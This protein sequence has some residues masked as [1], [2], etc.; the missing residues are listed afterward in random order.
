MEVKKEPIQEENKKD[1]TKAIQEKFA[2][3][4]EMQKKKVMET[5][6]T[7]GLDMSRVSKITNF[8]F[9]AVKSTPKISKML[10]TQKEAKSPLIFS[11]Y[12]YMINE[13]NLKKRK[14]REYYTFRSIQYTFCI[15]ELTLFRRSFQLLIFTHL[16]VSN[17]VLLLLQSILEK[18]NVK[19]VNNK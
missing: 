15:T 9:L 1:P 4:M 5:L 2:M 3:Q 19:L 8:D 17:R 13:A 16:L 12:I 6:A 11:D 7:T 14:A 18:S 10:Q